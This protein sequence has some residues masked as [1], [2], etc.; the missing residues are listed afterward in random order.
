[1]ATRIPPHLPRR[2]S[3]CYYG[4]DWLTSAR[5][6]EP[7]G[8]LPRAMRETRE[9]GFNCIRPDLG[10]GLLYDAAGTPRPPVEFAAWIPGLSDNLH[11]VN[12]LGG[13]VLDVRQRVFELFELAAEHD[14]FVIGTSWVYQDFIAQVADASLRA[15]LLAVP[16]NARLRFLA[17]QWG[18]LLTELRER[19]LLDRVAVAELANEVD[20][21]PLCAPWDEGDRG[22]TPE[23][24]L[25]DRHS[26]PPAEV[27]RELSA[28]CLRFLKQRHP[29]VLFDVDLCSAAALPAFAPQES[30][31]ADH[32][33]YC[34]GLTQGCYSA[35]GLWNWDPQTGPDIAANETLRALLKPDVVPW[36]E[37]TR[38]AAR[39]RAGWRA[40][41]WFHANLDVERYD[42]WCVAHFEEL[43]PSIDQP[44]QAGFAAARAYADETGKPL[45]VD[46]G[47]IFYPPLQSR[48]VTLPEGRYSEE[49]GV[50][51]ALETGH[52]GIL[53]TGYFR[54]NTLVWHEDDQCEWVK[55]LND[56]IL[57]S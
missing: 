9:R 12:G 1:M 46:E 39:V 40:V 18:R 37:F 57:A 16:Y 52:W 42:E 35:V 23:E 14:L 44:L 30:E 11:C 50:R 56:R 22:S 43:R 25:A 8:D 21:A 36:D 5:P 53:P 32:H 7:Y 26:R 49:Q 48:L 55:G 15:E 10:L 45:L 6:G 4:W 31:V 41:G 54:P 19:G 38:L 3:V 27:S 29:E 33:V 47:Y 20:G 24:W 13:Q 34:A 17:E 28:Q 51:L 2:L